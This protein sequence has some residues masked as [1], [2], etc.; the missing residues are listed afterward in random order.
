M[1]VVSDYFGITITRMLSKCRNNELVLARY[2]CF[3]F[4]RRDTTLTLKNVACLFG[5]RDHTTVIH[6]LASI[7]DRMTTDPDI[8]RIVAEIETLL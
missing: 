4:M 3:W 7:K 6:G 5:G 2:I 1:Q 8:R